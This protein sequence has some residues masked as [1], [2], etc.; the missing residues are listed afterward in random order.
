MQATDSTLPNRFLMQKL[1]S[2]QALVSEGHDPEEYIFD[3]EQNE[4][5]TARSSKRKL[6]GME[7]IIR[8]RTNLLVAE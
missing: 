1:D 2:L 4:K 5:K 6:Y 3:I 7:F 8:T